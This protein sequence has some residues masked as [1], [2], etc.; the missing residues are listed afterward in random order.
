[1]PCK[2]TWR[3]KPGPKRC[4]AI[5][6]LSAVCVCYI[7][8][9]RH[10]THYYIESGKDFIQTLLTNVMAP[11]T[12]RNKS[13]DLI[14]R[15]AIVDTRPRDNHANSTKI[16]AEASKEIRRYELI[17]GCNIDE[18]R[19]K[20]YT[21]KTLYWL[22]LDYNFPHLTHE[23]ILITCYDAPVLDSGSTA[24]VYYYQSLSAIVP[25]ERRVTVTYP[26]KTL[27]TYRARNT[28]V[29]CTTCFGRPPWLSQWLRYQK[30]LGVDLVT[31]VRRRYIYE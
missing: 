19:A 3:K 21:V 24:F 8:F 17:V 20:V 18:Y 14:I 2:S 5:I 29:V 30:T 25:T 12:S 23:E 15:S 11:T 1:M 31:N 13:F 28:V 6:L 9:S 22:W 10:S 7:A 16:F 27:S 26:G 4:I